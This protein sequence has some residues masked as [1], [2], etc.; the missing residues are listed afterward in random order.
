MGNPLA[1]KQ[2]LPPTHPTF[3]LQGEICNGTLMLDNGLHVTAAPSNGFPTPQ[4]CCPVWHNVL[5]ELVFHWTPKPCPKLWAQPWHTCYGDN[6][7]GI[8]GRILSL[9]T[10]LIAP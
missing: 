3:T 2:Q 4:I 10:K 7:Q 8:F 5:D 6:A 1:V 9:I